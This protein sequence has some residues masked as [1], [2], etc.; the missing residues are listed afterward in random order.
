MMLC[1]DSTQVTLPLSLMTF[2][3]PSTPSWASCDF[4]TVSP[5]KPGM[6]IMANNF[7]KHRPIS[8]PFDWIVLATLL[9]NIL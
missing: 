8:M 5:K 1:Q 2:E 6:H 9:D 3:L 4:Y 7:H